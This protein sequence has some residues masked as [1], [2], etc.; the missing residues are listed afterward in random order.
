MLLLKLQNK[1]FQKYPRHFARP[2]LR[3]LVLP[4]M[5]AQDEEQQAS[6]VVDAH[7]STASSPSRPTDGAE[8]CMTAARLRCEVF[9][10]TQ[11]P[12]LVL[13]GISALLLELLDVRENK[14]D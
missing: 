3:E 9:S 11:A 12:A 7:Q 5:A 8:L 4:A 6:Q 1:G 14:E 10:R 13:G 2:P